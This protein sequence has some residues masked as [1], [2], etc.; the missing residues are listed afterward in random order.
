VGTEGAAAPFFSPDSQWVGFFAGGKLKRIP[1]TGGAALIVCDALDSL[2]GSWAPND[3]IY[4]APGSSSGLWQVPAKGGTPQP[5]TKL[6]LQKG[7][8]GHRWPQ[9]PARRR[10][11]PFFF[12]HWPWLG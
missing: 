11:G 5:F 9:G 6:D 4:F 8:I 12:S 3:V 7:E 1:V 2:G 10:R